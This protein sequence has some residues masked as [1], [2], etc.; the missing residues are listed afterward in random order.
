MITTII[1]C[2]LDI[3]TVLVKPT[4]LTVDGKEGMVTSIKEV[5]TTINPTIRN[6]TREMVQITGIKL[7]IEGIGERIPKM[8]AKLFVVIEE[9]E[10]VTDTMKTITENITTEP[11]TVRMTTLSKEKRVNQDSYLN[12]H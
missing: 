8:M 4:Y 1:I 7:V 9:T 5:S 3:V 2:P 6:V 11:A 12:V 10:P